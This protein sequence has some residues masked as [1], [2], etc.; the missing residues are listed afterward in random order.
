MRIL[1]LSLVVGVGLV[2]CEEA[3]QDSESTLITKSE[4]L[5]ASKQAVLDSLASLEMEQQ[6]AYCINLWD[7]LSIMDYSVTPAKWKKTVSFGKK[8]TMLGDTLINKKTYTKVQLDEGNSTTMGWVNSYCI[9]KDAEVAI[10]TSETKIFQSNDVLSLSQESLGIGEIIAIYSDS[11]GKYFQFVSEKKAQS[12]YL[13]QKDGFS[14]DEKVI[15]AG[16]VFKQIMGK[17]LKDRL[18]AFEEFLEDEDYQSTV[19]GSK[20]QSL[21]D[22]DVENAIMEKIDSAAEAIP[23]DDQDEIMETVSGKL[24]F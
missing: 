24:D 19:F 10:T 4:D 11:D 1:F 3:Q 15:E 12:G 9:A 18:F 6:V 5:A 16:L 8:M 23:I 2:S 14:T 7:K 17:D 13:N 20:A 22:D 21:M